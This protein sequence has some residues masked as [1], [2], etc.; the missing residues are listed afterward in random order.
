MPDLRPGALWRVH[1]TSASVQ[2]AGWSDLDHLEVFL[3]PQIRH[4]QLLYSILVSRQKG[5]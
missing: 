5:R 1:T 4:I 2:D 3:A